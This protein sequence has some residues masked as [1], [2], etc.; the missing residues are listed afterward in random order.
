VL[1]ALT[2]KGLA[3]EKAYAMV[4]RNAMKTWTN[5][6][7]FREFLLEDAEV[8]RTLT[9]REVEALFSLDVHLRQIDNTF[10]KVGI[11]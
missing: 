9:R 1:L 10:K 11:K 4:Q 2:R 3:R 6:K 8:M 5:T 7:R